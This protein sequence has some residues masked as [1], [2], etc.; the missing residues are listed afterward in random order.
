MALS[1]YYN[2]PTPEL[3]PVPDYNFDPLP[4]YFFDFNDPFSF[5]P[6]YFDSLFSPDNNF[7]STAFESSYDP[8]ETH[9]PKRYKQVLFEPELNGPHGFAIQAANEVIGPPP[10]AQ[11]VV[12]R[13]R[14][15][16]I[17]EKTRELGNLVPGAHRMN[18]AEMFRAAYKYIE[19]LRAQ[20]GV[21][22]FMGSYEKMKK[23]KYVYESDEEMN[24]L[25]GSCLV[26]EKLYGA[27]RC[28][29]PSE[30][31]RGLANEEKGF[32]GRAHVMEQVKKLK[33]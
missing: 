10:S 21:L 4:D 5:D 2:F 6:N 27:G 15:R 31:V 7:N 33:F 30:F 24:G 1:H 23:Y 16:R 32:E 25:L 11:S 19:F 3:E 8:Q 17:S 29:V 22:E 9:H 14:R 28:M 18:T 26:Q 13:E 20:V 12:A